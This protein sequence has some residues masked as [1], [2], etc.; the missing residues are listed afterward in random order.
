M[1]GGRRPR[2]QHSL[3]T[4]TVV[5]AAQIIKTLFLR[6]LHTS[7]S[8]ILPGLREG[9]QQPRVWLRQYDLDP[10][11]TLAGWSVVRSI[12]AQHMTAIKKIK[13]N[14]SCRAFVRSKMGMCKRRRPKML[15]EERKDKLVCLY[16]LLLCIKLLVNIIFKELERK[17]KPNKAN[18]LLS[19]FSF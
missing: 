8:A 17:K 15:P 9:C 16:K 5:P 19:C 7:S 13:I 18:S 3:H 14:K 4:H 1:F 12:P 2:N 10:R 11:V 6:T